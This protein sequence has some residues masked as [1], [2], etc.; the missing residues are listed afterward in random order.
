V[1]VALLL[2]AGVVTAAGLVH[3]DGSPETPVEEPRVVAAGGA[4][5]DDGLPHID[6]GSTDPAVAHLDPRL[7]AAVRRAA[8]AAR[9]E[10]RTDFWVTSGWRSAATQQEL[11]DDAVAKHGS[12][13]EARKWVATPGTSEHVAGD[14]VDIGPTSAALWM[15]A[16]AAR[17]GLCRVY[18]NEVWHYELRPAGRT[19]CPSLVQDAAHRVR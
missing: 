13:A 7:R 18:A 19:T 14:A 2:V 6:P 17:F 9:T 12:E 5:G 8:A 1:A 16:N 15:D 11:L 10:G 4:T 3:D